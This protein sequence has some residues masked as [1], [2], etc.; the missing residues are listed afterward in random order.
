MNAF[1]RRVA[2]VAALTAAPALIALGA[3]TASQAQTTVTNTGP[4]TSHHQAF[5]HQDN[6]PQPGSQIHH[7]HQWH[8]AK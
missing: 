4:G 5:P 1:S 3:A 8:H 2:A 6:I 7:H